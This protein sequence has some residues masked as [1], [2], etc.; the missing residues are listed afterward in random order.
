MVR[1]CRPTRIS[2]GEPVSG[3]NIAFCV[4]LGLA[5]VAG[6]IEHGSV[7][8]S[9]A[10]LSGIHLTFS[11]AL[12]FVWFHLD[13]RERNYQPS[14][15]LRVL[16]V[17]LTV[18]ALPYYLFRSRGGWRGFKALGLTM[19]AFIAAMVLYRFGAWVAP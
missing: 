17:G 9:T 16:V 7:V 18:F 5:F 11:I 2:A 19:F 13:S 8:S 14:K 6:L 12:I 4:L 10:T 3:K 1:L 15:T